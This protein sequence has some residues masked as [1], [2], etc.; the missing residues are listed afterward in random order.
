[1]L[2]ECPDAIHPKQLGDHSYFAYLEVDDAD[3]YLARCRAA[4]FEP[5]REIADQPWGMRE[6][7]IAT[8]DG[9]RIMV[10]HQIG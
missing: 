7:P 2:G 8:P 1:M 9:H 10:G 5:R 6:F 4:G 3:A